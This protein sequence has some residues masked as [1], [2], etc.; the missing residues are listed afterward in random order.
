MVEELFKHVN[1][2]DAV[3][4]VYTRRTPHRTVVALHQKVVLGFCLKYMLPYPP[5]SNVYY[6]VY[7]V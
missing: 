5:G 2:Q 3:V 1:G 7:Y 4:C 6:N